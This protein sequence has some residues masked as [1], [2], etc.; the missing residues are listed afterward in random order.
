ERGL[1]L[2]I[3][4]QDVKNAVG[5]QRDTDHRDKQHDV[6]GEQASAGFCDGGFRHRWLRRV[7]AC[8]LTRVLATHEGL[9]WG[10]PGP[11]ERLRPDDQTRSVWCRT[12]R[13]PWQSPSHARP[14]AHVQ[15]KR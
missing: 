9:I 6:L 7:S 5:H 3:I 15:T 12:P 4:E 11:A 14:P 2:L 8:M 10:H 13:I 1:V